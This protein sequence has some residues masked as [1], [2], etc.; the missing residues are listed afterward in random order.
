MK[1]DDMTTAGAALYALLFAAI[2]SAGLLVLWMMGA[3]VR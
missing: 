2:A 3:G 1:H